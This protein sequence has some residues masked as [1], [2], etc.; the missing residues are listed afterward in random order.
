MG[1]GT[2]LTMIQ[3]TSKLPADA[4]PIR[5][6]ARAGMR[7]NPPP[8]KINTYTIL[9]RLRWD[10]VFIKRLEHASHIAQIAM[11]KDNLSVHGLP[12]PAMKSKR[13]GAASSKRQRDD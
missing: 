9:P 5:C 1:V 2:L 7:I 3:I 13:K 4:I 6:S 10:R 12:I 8:G 11:I